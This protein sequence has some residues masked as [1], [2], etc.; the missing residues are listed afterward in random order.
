MTDP[1]ASILGKAVRRKEDIR[2]IRGE[3]NFTDDLKAAGTLHAA[4]IRSS[5]ARARIVR[6]TTRT[7]GSSTL[8]AVYSARNFPCKLS[9]LPDSMITGKAVA[10]P[11]IVHTHS[12]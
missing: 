7:G 8:Q 11:Y 10:H 3:S 1:S 9:P 2:M 4:F 12:P 6:I 5:R